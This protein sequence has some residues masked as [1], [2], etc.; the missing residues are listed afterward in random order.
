MREDRELDNWRQQ[1]SS[2]A[3]PLPDIRQKI[4]RQNVRFV[5]SNLLAAVA[6]VAA[7]I[8]AI[9]I[10][11]MHPTPGERLDTRRQ[12]FDLGPA[13]DIAYGFSEKPGV[14]RIHPTHLWNFGIVE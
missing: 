4:K 6:F 5:L 2:L 1:W 7:M 8:C 11:Q 10:E 9:L 12:R 14:R 13:P 3:Q